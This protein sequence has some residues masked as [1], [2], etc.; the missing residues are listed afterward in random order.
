MMIVF[1][2][3]AKL[4]ELYQRHDLIVKTALKFLLMFL[5]F[6]KLSNVIGYNTG[7]SGFAVVLAL[8][9]FSAVLPPSLMVFVAAV[10]V[11]LQLITASVL[12]AVTVVLIFLIMYLFFLRFAP[13]EGITIIATPLLCSMGFPYV[14]PLFLGLFGSFFSAVPAVC[15]VVVFYLLK[16][17]NNN[18]ITIEELKA[19]KDEA[20][21]IYIKVLD[22]L[23][24]NPRMYV[25]MAIFAVVIVTIVFVRAIKM[26][27]AF[28]IALGVGT[29]VMILGY[30]LGSLKYEM[31]LKVGAMVFGSLVSMGIIFVCLFFYRV[32]NYSAAEHVQF[33]DE[34]YYYYVTAIPK[35]TAKSPRRAIRKVMSKRED[36]PEDE[37]EE[38]AIEAMNSML[39]NKNNPYKQELTAG[40]AKRLRRDLASKE[41]PDYD[42]EDEDEE[43]VIT[44]PKARESKKGIKAPID[45]II[46]KLRGFGSLLPAKKSRPVK[47]LPP[48]MDPEDEDDE[49][50]DAQLYFA[51]DSEDGGEDE[52]LR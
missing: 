48:A 17:V 31:D 8:S 23:L 27:Y 38:S 11:F 6:R 19:A 45:S 37:D 44:G 9:V 33:E 40:E 5:T 1:E 36:V 52:N 10:Y 46:S 34:R 42:N 50:E 26:D 24:K 3:R 32:L 39:A 13:K 28:E 35:I 30:I 2:I 22:D 21:A 43:V 41:E 20:L 25:V 49:D 51:D 12:I 14:V 29:G 7:L 18:I 16:A 47:P 4:T 15:G